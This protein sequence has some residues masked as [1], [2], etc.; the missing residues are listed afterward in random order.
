[1]PREFIVLRGKRGLQIVENYFAPD[2]AREIGSNF[3][4]LHKRK[5][6][7]VGEERNLLIYRTMHDCCE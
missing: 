6:S 2:T 3:T 1:V 4:D 5:N 7:N